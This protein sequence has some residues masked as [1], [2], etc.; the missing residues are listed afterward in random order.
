MAIDLFDTRTMLPM[1][2]EEKSANSFLKNRFFSDERRFETKKVDIDI[3][4]GKRRIAPFVHPKIGGKTVERDG[5]RTDSF[6]PPEVSPDM[7]TTAEDMLKRA[8][9]ETIYGAGSPDERAAAQIGRDLAE[10]DDMITRREEA[11]CSEA[12]FQ[13][14]VTVKGE[15]YDSVI[16]YWPTNPAEQPYLALGAGDRW[17]E[18]TSDIQKNLRDAELE[19]LQK[20]GVQA[21][22][23]IL[24]RDALDAF[25]NNATLA[26]NLDNRRIDTGQIDPQRLENGVRYWGYLKDSGLD[27]WSYDDWYID[28]ETGLEVPMVPTKSALIG[29]PRARTTMAYGCVVDV[30]KGSF[31]LPRVPVSWTQRKNPAGRIVQLKGKPLPIVHQIHGFKVLEVLA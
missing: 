31:A 8:P 12:L 25:L 26:K 9:G 3:Y 14:Q 28:P 1:L 18:S 22:D 27:I 16:A 7:V 23:V 17:N 19:I 13:G 6:E 4:V 29:S 24:G 30:E 5:Y 10:L 2:S 11:M 15:G 21:Q 20:S